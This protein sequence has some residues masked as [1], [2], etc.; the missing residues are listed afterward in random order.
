[1]AEKKEK[2]KEE[3]KVVFDRIYTIPLRSE[4]L[5]VP[6]YKRAEKAIRA[7]KQFLARHMKVEDRDVSKIKIDNWTNKA[8]WLRG[9]KK[10]SHKI[11]VKAT[12]LSDGTVKVEFLG[13]PASFKVEE[14]KLQ[15]KMEKAKKREEARAKEKEKRKKKEE[16]KK[17]EVVEE[18]SEEEKLAE[19]EK[20]EKEKMLHKTIEAEQPRIMKTLQHKESKEL[21][22]KALEK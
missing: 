12:K 17:P 8:I 15:R 22:R 4:W 20:K 7:M 21:R 5:K 18:K 11:K 16:E 2:A 19:E 10:P 1:M 9:I 14:E 13:L 6:K 3:V